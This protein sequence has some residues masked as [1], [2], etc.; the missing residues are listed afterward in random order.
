MLKI[1]KIVEEIYRI[2]KKSKS[3]ADNLF[4]IELYSSLYLTDKIFVLFLY[5]IEKKYLV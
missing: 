4:Y 2:S 1:H 3:M 5:I